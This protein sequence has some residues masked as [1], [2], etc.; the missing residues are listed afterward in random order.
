MVKFCAATANET[1]KVDFGRKS[2]KA[3]PEK[4]AALAARIFLPQHVVDVFMEP[5][6]N[7]LVLYNSDVSC[8]ARRMEMSP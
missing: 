6:Q 1:V 8:S 2:R 7:L 3:D 5:I 4:I